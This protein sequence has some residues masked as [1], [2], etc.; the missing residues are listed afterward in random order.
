[1]F[2]SCTNYLVFSFDIAKFQCRVKVHSVWIPFFL[3]QWSRAKFEQLKKTRSA[4]STFPL[5]K[6]FW[7]PRSTKFIHCCQSTGFSVAHFGMTTTL[8]R[9]VLN[10]FCRTARHSSW[11]RRREK[12]WKRLHMACILRRRFANSLQTPDIFV[13]CVFKNPFKFQVCYNIYLYNKRLGRCMFICSYVRM[14]V[15][16]G[17]PNHWA[18]LGETW[19]TGA[20][21]P[22][23]RP[24][25]G[26]FPSP[27]YI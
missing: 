12:G 23:K 15:W 17:R 5:F 26:F 1:M 2:K 14:F 4:V 18:D 24:R 11:D 21:R 16:N 9:R 13:R 7:A 20:T 6:C 3:F 27:I 22:G 10:T 25:L 8:G 19:L